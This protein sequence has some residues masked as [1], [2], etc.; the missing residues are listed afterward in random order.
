MPL[1]GNYNYASK[2]EL[3]LSYFAR[4]WIAR[5]AEYSGF[6]RQE[7]YGFLFVYAWI[8][9]HNSNDKNNGEVIILDRINR[10]V[11]DFIRVDGHLL[12]TDKWYRSQMKPS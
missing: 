5:P 10:T 9:L 11:D 12:E 3:Q 2:I 6:S 7:R 4:F 8:S 1:L